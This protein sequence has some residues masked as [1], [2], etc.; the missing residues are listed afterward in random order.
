[1]ANSE[2]LAQ[3]RDIHL[4]DPISWWP[5]APGWYGLMALAVLLAIGISYR[6]YKRHANALAK[7]KALALLSMYKEQYEKDGNAQVASARISEL[8][9]RVALVYYPRSEVA[10]IHGDGWID[11]LNKTGKNIDFRPVRAQLLESPFKTAETVK[12][13][14]LFTRAEQWIKQRGVPCLN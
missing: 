13:N 11:F 10:S 5:L 4:P 14:P 8:L 7:N 2:P 1:V 12:L 6:L 3:L 9:R